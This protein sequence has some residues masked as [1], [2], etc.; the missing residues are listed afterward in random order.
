METGNMNERLF[1]ASSAIFSSYQTYISLYDVSN[2]DEILAIFKKRLLEIFE[3][4][5]LEYLSEKVEKT[6]FHIHSYTIEQILVSSPES[7]FYICDHC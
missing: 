1:I 2:I 3:T 7:H 5:K 6:N 4:N